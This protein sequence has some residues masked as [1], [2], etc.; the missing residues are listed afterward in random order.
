M[1]PA[2]R[3]GRRLIPRIRSST[4]GAL[5]GFIRRISDRAGQISQRPACNLFKTTHPIYGIIALSWL[6]RLQLSLLE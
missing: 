2:N 5:S 4:C 3:R 1:L 6:L